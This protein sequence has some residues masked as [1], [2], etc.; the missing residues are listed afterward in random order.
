MDSASNS[1]SANLACSQE[2]L[3]FGCTMP[4]HSQSSP[5]GELS[6]TEKFLEEINDVLYEIS[7]DMYILTA[8]QGLEPWQKAMFVQ[9]I[10][11]NLGKVYTYVEQRESIG[12][13]TS[14]TDLLLYDQLG[15][16][17]QLMPDIY[18]NMPKFKSFVKKMQRT[19]FKK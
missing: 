9:K 11:K 19:H 14:A 17:Q 12:V 1:D 18:T 16:L 5:A 3:S 2:T 10:E 6:Y 8:Y 13:D 15:I 4:A 7:S